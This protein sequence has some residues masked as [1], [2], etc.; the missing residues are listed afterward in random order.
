MDSEA[1]HLDDE[2]RCK[3]AV[4]GKGISLRCKRLKKS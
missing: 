2:V 1:F 3:A 4:E